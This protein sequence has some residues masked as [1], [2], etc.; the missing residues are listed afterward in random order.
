[1][2][3]KIKKYVMEN[4]M[5]DYNDKVVVGVSGGADSVCLF[6]ILLELQKI[7]NLSLF[8]VHINHGI[9]GDEAKRDETFVQSLCQTYQIPYKFFRYSVEEMAKEKRM[10]SEEMGRILRYQSF[11]QMRKEYKAQKIAVAHNKNDQSET[12]L[13]NLFRGSGLR[14]L[15]GI[16]CVRG[17]IIRPLLIVS[18]TEIEL[19]LKKRKQSY[20]VDSS[21]LKELYT[22][23]KIRL[24]LLPYIERE[25]NSQVYD[26]IAKTAGML[27]EVEE[28]IRKNGLIAKEKIVRCKNGKYFLDVKQ[29]LMEDSI[30]QKELLRIV[31]GEM[32]SHL[33]NIEAKHITMLQCLATKQV[34]KE[35]QLPYHIIAKKTYDDIEIYISTVEKRST[36]KKDEEKSFEKRTIQ[37]II[38]IDENISGEE[39]IPKIDVFFFTRELLKNQ[40]IPKNS[41]TKW[42]D[43]AKIANTVTLR[44]R[45]EG[46]FL[47]IDDQGRRKKLNR[48]L[49]D[50]K[51][52]KEQRDSLFLLADGN[53]IIWIIGDRIS[54]AYKIDENTKNI[55][56]VKVD[57]G[58]INVE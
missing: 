26:H 45:Q 4:N 24:S 8:V 39:S 57:G 7:Y 46:D 52:P 22:R 32:T 27:K 54:Q 6:F 55:L 9:R 19:Y 48:I 51:V 42:F 34:G 29:F 1:M 44:H 28:Y 17:V 3:H 33:K 41:C 15:T 13:L 35:L 16:T 2:F 25:I 5:L 31:L 11:E 50:N 40:K 21:N 56:I 37:N 10:S 30:I 20:C 53:H 36:L 38:K 47:Q 18:R 49:I 14:G 23:N 58:T 43:Y 12:V